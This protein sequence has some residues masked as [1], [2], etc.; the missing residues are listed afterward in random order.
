M[1]ENSFEERFTANAYDI[2]LHGHWRPAALLRQ[3]SLT[4][5]N[6]CLAIDQE[7]RALHEFGLFWVLMRVKL[8]IHAHPIPGEDLKILTFANSEKGRVFDRCFQ[9]TNAK[10]ENLALAS[11]I[12]L[13]LKLETRTVGRLPADFPLLRHVTGEF[14]WLTE[15]PKSINCK[16]EVIKQ[17]RRRVR[18]SELD[19]NQHMNNT[20]YAE[21]VCDLL[22]REYLE[23]SSLSSIQ[24]N[25]LKEAACDQEMTLS[26]SLDGGTFFVRGRDEEAGVTFFEARGLLAKR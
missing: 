17:E 24:I 7:N 20:R 16:L 23:A 1:S 26:L 15:E 14:T 5:L 4:A 25:Y 9:I 3:M 18:Y 22:D 2:D 13:L 8:D 11:T 6:H 19:E 10:G 21:W 12:W